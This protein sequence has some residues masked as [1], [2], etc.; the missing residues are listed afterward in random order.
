MICRT[1]ILVT[2]TRQPVCTFSF[3]QRLYTISGGDVATYLLP[4]SK[5][6]FTDDKGHE[7]PEELV[8]KHTFRNEKEKHNIFTLSSLL[9]MDI[10]WKYTSFQ[11]L[12]SLSR[13]LS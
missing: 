6:I 1:R 5:L 7:Y 13:T 12:H 3:R 9:G 4:K 10:L 11:Q 8:L 2:V